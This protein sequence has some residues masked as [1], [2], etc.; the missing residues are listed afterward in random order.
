MLRKPEINLLTISLAPP[1]PESGMIPT[2]V[3]LK[4]QDAEVLDVAAKQLGLQRSALMRLLLVRGA[5][6]ILTELG[7]EL[8]YEQNSHVDLSRGETLIE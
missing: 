5:E 6:R 7:V 3:R 2:V 1:H 4:G 8:V